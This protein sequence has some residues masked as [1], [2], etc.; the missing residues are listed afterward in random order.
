MILKPRLV[1]WSHQQIDNILSFYPNKKF[2]MEYSF[3]KNPISVAELHEE[4][5]WSETSCLLFWEQ[6]K[7]IHSSNYMIVFMQ[8]G[9]LVISS[10]QPLVDEINKGAIIG[11]KVSHNEVIYS[12]TQH[13]MVYSKDGLQFVDGG[14]VYTRASISEDAVPC[15]LKIIDEFGL[16]V[17]EEPVDLDDL[18]TDDEVLSSEEYHYHLIV[19]DTGNKIVKTNEARINLSTIMEWA[20]N[21]IDYIKNICYLGYFTEKEFYKGVKE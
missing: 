18:E 8:R 2:V 3:P 14:P 4:V 9:N 10:G 1:Q 19:T 12:T 5:D 13:D 21:D 17:E 7:G 16:W 6:D 15:R 20:G 11:Y